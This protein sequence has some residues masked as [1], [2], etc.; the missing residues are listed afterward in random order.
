MM[1]MWKLGGAL[2]R[3][4]LR[5]NNAITSNSCQ[6]VFVR[7]LSSSIRLYVGNLD[8]TTTKERLR[9]RFELFGQVENI[10]LPMEGFDE[11]P[12]GFAF[13][14]MAED[15]AR[16]A[17]KNLDASELDGRVIRI[18]ETEIAPPVGKLFR[19]RV[20]NDEEFNVEGHPEVPN[21]LFMTYWYY[22]FC[23]VML[24]QE[25]LI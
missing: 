11:R 16:E 15:D 1:M 5:A 20:V 25:T 19:D 7:S 14:T 23:F 8:F 12:R 17:L 22:I 24:L 6:T 18:E 21:A 9:E 2:T 4:G 10:H 13:V 3:S